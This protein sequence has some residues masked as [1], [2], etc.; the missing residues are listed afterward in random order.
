MLSCGREGEGG[1]AIQHVVPTYRHSFAMLA[2]TCSA[3]HGGSNRCLLL[4]MQ[5]KQCKYL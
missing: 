3:A 4:Q 2:G 5:K 1:A